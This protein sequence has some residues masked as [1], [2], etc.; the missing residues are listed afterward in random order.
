MQEPGTAPAW[1]PADRHW[2]SPENRRMSGFG[3]AYGSNGQGLR[4]YSEIPSFYACGRHSLVILL[5]QQGI[6]MGNRVKF[7]SFA[8]VAVLVA[9]ILVY[10]FFFRSPITCPKAVIYHVDEDRYQVLLGSC[11]G[12]GNGLPP[13]YSLNGGELTPGVVITGQAK[14]DYGFW[15]VLWSV[16]WSW[17]RWVVHRV[18]VLPSQQARSRKHL[19]DIYPCKIL[20]SGD[21]EMYVY[22]FRSVAYSVE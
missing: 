13:V 2:E 15:N 14:D 6:S 17:G 19:D 18:R 9:A 1:H 20:D 4:D 21:I 22:T 16:E 10:I 5:M 12:L 3:R 11:D 8:I 7:V